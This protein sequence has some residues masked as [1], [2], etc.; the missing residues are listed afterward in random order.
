MKR[1]LSTCL[2][3]AALGSAATAATSWQFGGYG[4]VGYNSIYEFRGVDLGS[5]MAEASATTTATYGD[6]VFSASAWYAA[7]NDNANNPTPNELDLTLAFAKKL[8]PVNLT[9]GYI[10]YSF[11]DAS[12]FNAQE[13]YL[14][15]GM[16]VYAGVSANVTAY[17]EIDLFNG[18]YF[19]FNLSKTCEVSSCLSVVSTAG[20]GFAEDNGWQLKSNGKPLD[21][22]QQWY[23]S[24]SMP[25][26]F[27]EGFT[28]AP[29][30]RYVDA[31]SGL[32]NDVPG[33]G[34][35]GDHLIY[36]A[37]LNFNF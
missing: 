5:N 36:G 16:D 31:A 33:G 27:H 21:G 12:A 37:K 18:W 32:V 8:G 4:L 6:L 23:L 20:C 7:I 14:G 35:G 19:D 15:A 28:L 17:R 30:V 34:T 3:L 29:Y 26:K 24:V 9:G 22:F 2:I 25:W 11:N 1:T 13:L 10:Y